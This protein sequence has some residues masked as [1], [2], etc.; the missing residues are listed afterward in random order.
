MDLMN[1]LRVN[2]EDIPKT[3]FRTRYGHHEF[4]VMPFGLTN[5]PA[6][7]LDLMNRVCR[8]YLD[9]FVILFIDDILIYSKNE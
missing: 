4:V 5:A 1:R 3:A 7:F 9:Q 2:D 6:V 8:P